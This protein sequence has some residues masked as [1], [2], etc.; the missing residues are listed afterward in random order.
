MGYLIRVRTENGGLIITS[1]M[2]KEGPGLQGSVE[3]MI[4]PGHSFQSD[5]SLQKD[6]P[7]FVSMFLC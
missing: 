6:V 5:D 3:F 1:A 4:K 2:R 7:V